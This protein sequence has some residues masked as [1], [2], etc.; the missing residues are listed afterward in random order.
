[1]EQMKQYIGTKIIK[2]RPGTMAEAQ[3]LKCGCPVEVQERIFKNSGT[4]NQKGY[5][6]EYEDGYISWSP[7]HAFEGAYR[8]CDNM[9]FGLAL[10]AM[11]KG[12]MVAR[13]CWICKSIYI[14]D[15]SRV[16][17]VHLRAD[18]IKNYCKS[19]VIQHMNINPHIDMKAADG[20]LVIGWTPSQLD[21]L[22]DD[23]VIVG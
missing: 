1:M 12:C 21:M 7:T 2:A 5:I 17:S 15:G 11:K 4:V 14:Q 3:A 19:R 10:E 6:V 9:T 13:K 16:E 20:S 22:A 23:W 8:P 18:A